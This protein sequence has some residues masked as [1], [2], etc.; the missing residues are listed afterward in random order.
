MGNLENK[1]KLILDI[2]KFAVKELG[3]APNNSFK[4][5]NNIDAVYALYA[6]RKDKIKSVI[7][8]KW[9]YK[10]YENKND[11]EKEEKFLKARGYDVLKVKF[12]AWADKNFQ[13][14]NSLIAC[15]KTRIAYIVLHENFHIHCEEK[16]IFLEPSIEE[17]LGDCFAYQGSLEYFASNSSMIGH[18]KKD[19]QE[20]QKFFYFV[21]KYATILKES[22][23]KSEAE[24]RKALIR[25]EREGKK[26]QNIVP[27]INNAFFVSQ[28]LYA[29]MA[30]PV[31][32]AFKDIEP[33]EYITNR[34]KIYDALRKIKYK[35]LN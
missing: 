9:K 22:Y 32:E 11:C 34:K 21:N 14:T 16:K 27:P 7:G 3:I 25:A 33:R 20:W 15:S 10:P 19:F 24:G 12:E 23:K 13:I 26:I 8:G 5:V 29:S 4:R 17:S 35:K 31:Y 6:S 2:K 30:K 18:I 28:E 1:T